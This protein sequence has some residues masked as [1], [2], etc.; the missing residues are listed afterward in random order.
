LI[1]IVI[2]RFQHP[3]AKAGDGA[4][5]KL[6]YE[7]SGNDESRPDSEARGQK[8]EVRDQISDF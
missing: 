6:R 4:A 1:L 2:V 3:T 5:E 7:V 8:S